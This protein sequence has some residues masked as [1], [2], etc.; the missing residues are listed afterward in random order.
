MQIALESQQAFPTGGPLYLG[1]IWA[2][3]AMPWC[4]THSEDQ[5]LRLGT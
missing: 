3:S 1:T 2:P 5:A 4:R